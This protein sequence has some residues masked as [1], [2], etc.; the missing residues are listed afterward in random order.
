MKRLVLV[1]AV[2]G[3]AYLTYL[4]AGVALYA[5]QTRPEALTKGILR[6]IV[7][8]DGQPVDTASVSVQSD[9]TN[10][11]ILITRADANHDYTFQMKR[12]IYTVVATLPDHAI[13]SQRVT[14][15]AGRIARLTLVP[16]AIPQDEQ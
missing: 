3:A 10:D 16:T 5:D 13:A 4:F 2:A 1:V 12:G 9:S 7:E 14:I 8:S 15:S 6:V 11:A